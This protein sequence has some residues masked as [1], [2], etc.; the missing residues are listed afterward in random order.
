MAYNFLLLWKEIYFGDHNR[1]TFCYYIAH[2]DY[3]SIIL[4]KAYHKLM[5]AKCIL[6]IL[7]LLLY[8]II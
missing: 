7:L 4:N 8:L 6:I 3:C 1:P 5:I 2:A